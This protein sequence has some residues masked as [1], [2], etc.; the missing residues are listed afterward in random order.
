MKIQIL[1]NPHHPLPTPLPPD[2]RGN[3]FLSEHDSGR[4]C[5]HF[6][7]YYVYLNLRNKPEV[8][9]S[10]TVCPFP[11]SGGGRLGWGW[12]CNVA[13]VLCSAA[14]FD[15]LFQYCFS[16]LQN[17]IIPKPQHPITLSIQ[18]RR[19]LLVILNLFRMLSTVQ[20][21][22]QTML[23]TDKIDDISAYCLL[24]S[25]FYS[26]HPFAAQVTPQF[27]LGQSHILLQI[28]DILF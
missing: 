25:E 5:H 14:H 6:F 21:N 8:F 18:K 16:L 2:G 28:T 19:P 27:L 10:A 1:Y 22:N 24:A 15:N 23:H 7:Q 20:F 4:C 11:P 12:L 3:R 17:F 13:A 9:K 26:V